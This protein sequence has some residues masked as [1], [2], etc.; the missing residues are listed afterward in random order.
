VGAGRLLTL[1]FRD[2]DKAFD[3]KAVYPGGG[4]T[5]DA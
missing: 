3:P 5:S 2:G 4:N 1:E